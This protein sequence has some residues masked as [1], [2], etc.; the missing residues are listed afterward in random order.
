MP[1]IN[2]MTRAQI[3]A[4]LADLEP[5]RRAV[6]AA[7]EWFARNKGQSRPAG[8]W[9]GASRYRPSAD[10]HRAC[11]DEI[12]TPSRA[13]PYSLWSHVH[14][15]VH[16]AALHDVDPAHVRR[17]AKLLTRLSELEEGDVSINEG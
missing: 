3:E 2:K 16:V 7:R 17:A 14:S 5:T 12:R 8:R 6:H 4:A 13:H 15:A 10:E 1:P 11:C 9:D